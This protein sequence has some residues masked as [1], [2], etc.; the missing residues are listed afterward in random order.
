[1]KVITIDGKTTM[2][3]G[4]K[5]IAKIYHPNKFH[6]LEFSAEYCGLAFYYN[7]LESAINGITE[8]ENSWKNVFILA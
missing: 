3:N 8:K 7:S 4:R 6:P 1:M 5:T 2:K